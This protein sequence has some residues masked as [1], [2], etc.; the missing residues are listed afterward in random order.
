M[1]V[2]Q[3]PILGYCPPTD[4]EV[5]LNRE[6]YEAELPSHSTTTKTT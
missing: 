3:Y 5:K 6:V 4:M 2:T 1:G